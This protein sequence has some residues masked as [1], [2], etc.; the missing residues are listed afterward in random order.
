MEEEQEV[1]L[2]HVCKFCSKSFS[3]GRSLG[4][5][6]RSHMINDITSQADGTTLTK[7]KLPSLVVTTTTTAAAATEASNSYVLRENPKKTWRI[8]DQETSVLDKSCKECGKVF[9]SWKA[10]FAHIK[11]HSIEKDKFLII[12]QEQEEHQED[13]WTSVM[14]SESD[15]ET[16]APRHRKKRSVRRTR[17]IMGTTTANSS[18]S[19]C[20][21][22]T[23]NGSS[24]VTENDQEQE[25]VAICLM[26]LSRD[27]GGIN[28]S[29]A[30]SSDNNFDSR[31]TENSS[32]SELSRKLSKKK[33]PQ[34]ESQ[35]DDESVVE[36][37][38]IEL[39]KRKLI[40]SFVDPE[41]NSRFECN[42]CN[43]IF[44][45]YQALGGH[46]ASHKKNK[47]CYA[48]SENSVEETLQSSPDQP[49]ETPS[50]FEKRAAE[51]TKKTK[52]GHHVCPICFKVF[53]SGQALGGHK[54]SHL[55][56]TTI[57]PKNNQQPIPIPPPIRDFLDLNLPAPAEE[58]S[59]G[60]LGFNQWW[61]S[62][63]HKH[64][65]LVGLISN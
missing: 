41:R 63:T 44:H 18:S 49:D 1:V 48:S 19:L 37:S 36:N 27:V 8:P 50:D 9:Q 3:C 42:T 39:G 38:G 5:H 30:E 2:K 10:L 17:K 24:S 54:R 61:I 16:A 13:S 43:K 31:K 29:V 12:E 7:K 20:F 59:N 60:L 65:S 6:M 14:D 45:S 52:L 34:S 26:M 56:T 21:A 57:E 51:T 46:R 28:N 55:V 23:N 33:K 25:E 35:Q 53:P 64:E 4:G 22:N 47:G 15:N 40:D 32:V 58:E 62:S 11:N